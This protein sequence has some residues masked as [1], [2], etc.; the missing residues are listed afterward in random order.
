MTSSAI[1]LG[2][3]LAVGPHLGALR[4]NGIE[5]LVVVTS[6]ADRAERVRGI[7]PRAIVVPRLDD[8][9]EAVDG[10]PD[11]G[12]VASP[13]VAHLDG[14]RAFA[15]RGVDV[16][17]EKPFCLTLADALASRDAA[18]A[19]GTRLAVSFQHRFKP[20]TA[21]ARE[22]VASGAIG[23]VVAAQV[24][25]PWW[26]SQ[27]YYD[28]PGRGDADRDGGGVLITQAV[29]VLDLY[30]SLFGSVERVSA[31]GATTSLHRMQTEDVMQL[32]LVHPTFTT[33]VLATTA[34]RPGRP[35]TIE[36]LGTEGRLLFEGSAL[37]VEDAEGG[38]IAEVA[39]AALRGGGI[40]PTRMTPWFEAL[41]DDVLSSWRAG[42]A[43]LADVDAT[44]ETRRVVDAAYRSLSRDGEWAD[45]A[46]DA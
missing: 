17:C 6:N 44:I 3:G 23:E 38:V 20:A 29:H 30:L 46:G 40:D 8:A 14:V 25:V 5:R 15:A 21:A 32:L 26:R 7:D 18:R 22:V 45:I 33:T 35:E 41:Y 42:R 9:F 36:V 37:R 24:R 10:T 11:L 43:S 16:V 12:V 39:P 34:S 28:E 4:S 13:P 19:A 2:A 27:D 31:L 1:V